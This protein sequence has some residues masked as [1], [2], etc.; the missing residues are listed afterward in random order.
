[1]EPGTQVDDDP[2]DDTLVV[3]QT[4]WDIKT[5]VG[6]E[7]ECGLKPPPKSSRTPERHFCE[8]SENHR[9]AIDQANRR[10]RK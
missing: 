9:Y 5:R 2:M 6:Y 10:K 4:N 3:A 7:M 8:E 1:M